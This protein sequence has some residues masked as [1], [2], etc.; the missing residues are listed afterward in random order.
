MAALIAHDP[1]KSKHSDVKRRFVTLL[2]EPAD[3]EIRVK[4]GTEIVLRTKQEVCCYVTSMP[5]RFEYPNI[6]GQ[7]KVAATTRGWGVVQRI[8]ELCEQ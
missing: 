6:E 4:H 3:G 5:G 2:R 8:A 1:F 7:L